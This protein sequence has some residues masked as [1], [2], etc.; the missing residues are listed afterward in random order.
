MRPALLTLVLLLLAIPSA[1]EANSFRGETSQHRFASM[2]VGDDGAVERI[3]ISYSAPCSEPGY[4]FPNVLRIESPFD[5]AT[6]DTLTEEL[7]LRE[8]LRDGGRSRQTVAITAERTVDDD[9]EESWSGTF[10]T[11]IVLTRDGKRLDTCQLKR[12]TWSVSAVN[13]P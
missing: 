11:R 8:R 3:R 6:P 12:V 4:R 2:V 5:Q 9:G 7:V 10:R 1:A 13:L